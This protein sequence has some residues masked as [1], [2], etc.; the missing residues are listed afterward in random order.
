MTTITKY[1]CNK[2]GED[3]DKDPIC[4][5][6]WNTKM[7]DTTGTS[8]TC[9]HFCSICEKKIR[10]DIQSLIDCRAIESLEEE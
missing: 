7:R 1:F 3:L 4:S 8:Q 9:V 5:Q 10:F 6:G 2:C